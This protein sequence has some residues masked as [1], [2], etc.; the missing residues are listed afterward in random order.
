MNENRKNEEHTQ[1]QKGVSPDRYRYFYHGIALIVLSTAVTW[2]GGQA[3]S[4]WAGPALSLSNDLY[5]PSAMLA[6][7]RGFHNA[8]AHDLPEFSEF[9]EFNRPSLNRASIQSMPILPLSDHQAYHVYLLGTVGVWWRLKGITWDAFKDLSI[10]FLVLTAW[11]IY[12]CMT[13]FLPWWLAMPL[14]LISITAPSVLF[15]VQYLR[16]FAK[17]P[18]IVAGIWVALLFLKKGH[19]TRDVLI[20]AAAAGLLTGIGLGFRRDLIIMPPVFL[21]ILTLNPLGGKISRLNRWKSRTAG[22]LILLLLIGA[23]GWPVWRAFYLYGSLTDH[24]TL[25]GFA[26]N[27]DVDMR[28]LPGSY[29]KLP[30]LNDLYVSACAAAHAALKS[31]S[32]SSCPEWPVT[33]PPYPDSRA[34]QRLILHYLTHYPWDTLVVRWTA[35]AWTL[36]SGGIAYGNPR[37][38]RIERAGPLLALIVSVILLVRYGIRGLLMSLLLYVF[39]GY[40]CLQFSPRHVFQFSF[41]P[42]LSAGICILY[43]LDALQAAHRYGRTG[44][45]RSNLSTIRLNKPLIPALAAAGFIL[46]STA[47]MFHAWQQHYVEDAANRM[48]GAI[49]PEISCQKDTWDGVPLFIPEKGGWP[50]EHATD[51]LATAPDMMMMMTCRVAMF[52]RGVPPWAVRLVY[53]DTRGWDGFTSPVRLY[54]PDWREIP[55]YLCFP[56]FEVR[57][58]GDLNHFVGVSV[59]APY[60]TKFLGFREVNPD[61]MPPEAATLIMGIPAS[62]FPRGFLATQSIRSVFSPERLH[63]GWIHHEPRMDVHADLQRVASL[64]SES[65]FTEARTVIDTWL[66]QRPSSLT[67]NLAAA[68]A[69]LSEGRTD[70]ARSLLEAYLSRYCAGDRKN[71]LEPYLRKQIQP[72]SG[73]E[74]TPS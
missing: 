9:L 62:G 50:P 25:M 23:T 44:E 63:P 17:A 40:T 38:S 24:D 60:D 72:E 37:D 73:S 4:N 26:T 48:R 11:L 43:F 59:A 8:P 68:R 71:L 54:V 19:R 34:K 56:V 15:T 39:P 20:F 36:A 21:G 28:I 46:T 67:W 51:F 31:G 7:G 47:V 22:I 12:G 65:R 64:V 55:W 18:F 3:F 6:A 70:S 42:W 30:I 74:R 58:G 32:A 14:T 41:L 53:E 5:I 16:D 10:G 61:R 45:I 1:G 69:L 35:A 66:K 13:V 2:V 49:G 33:V 29:E 52:D 27:G 57:Q